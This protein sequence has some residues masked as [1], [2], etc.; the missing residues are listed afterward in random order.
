MNKT[1]ASNP[2]L[3]EAGRFTPRRRV[4]SGDRRLRILANSTPENRGHSL[5]PSF[6]PFTPSRPNPPQFRLDPQLLVPGIFDPFDELVPLV[7]NLEIMG[8][9]EEEQRIFNRGAGALNRTPIGAG[10]GEADKEEPEVQRSSGRGKARTTLVRPTPFA[11]DRNRTREE[12]ERDL[13]AAN[14]RMRQEDRVIAE[15]RAR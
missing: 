12:I 2:I 10:R 3:E 11:P 5:S 8:D 7:E 6:S 14:A 13:E 15:T 4:F 9:E 1:R